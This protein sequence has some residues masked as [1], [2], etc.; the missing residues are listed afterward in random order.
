MA[1]ARM[2]MP[3]FLVVSSVF[4]NKTPPFSTWSA[5]AK[6]RLDHSTGFA[7]KSQST[8]SWVA[9]VQK[10]AAQAPENAKEAFEKY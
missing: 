3:L 4:L 2:F 10:W 8:K 6:Y 9:H 7:G 1:L 5:M